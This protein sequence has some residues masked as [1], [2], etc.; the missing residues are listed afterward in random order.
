[1]ARLRTEIRGNS[2]TLKNQ[3][4]SGKLKNLL[5]TVDT[6]ATTKAKMTGWDR[7]EPLNKKRK[8]D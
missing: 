7:E 2:A 3:R 8:A 1:L 5:Y 4:S 6:Y